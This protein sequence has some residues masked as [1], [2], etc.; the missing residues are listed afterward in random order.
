M[1]FSHHAPEVT[2]HLVQRAGLRLEKVEMLKQDN[3]EA[4]F[5]W[6]TGYKLSSGAPAIPTIT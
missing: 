2:K 4:V 3:E 1:F 6:I 5:L